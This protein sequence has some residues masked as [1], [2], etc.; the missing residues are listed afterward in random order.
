MVLTPSEKTPLTAVRLAELL[1]EAGLPGWMLSVLVGE[2]DEVVRPLV[3][4]ERVA[5][6]SFTGGVAAGREVASTARLTPAKGGA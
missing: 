5:M 2:L 3:R 6:V 1:Y 4:D